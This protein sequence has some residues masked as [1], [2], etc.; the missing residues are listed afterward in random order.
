MPRWWTIAPTL[1][2][3]ASR[4]TSW[5]PCAIRAEGPGGTP[6]LAELAHPV[7]K[8]PRQRNHHIPADF[9]TIL[10]KALAEFPHERYATA[11][12]LADDLHRFLEGEPI[13]ASP[14]S[15]VKPGRQ[16]GQ[17]APG[18]GRGGGRHALRRHHRPSR[19]PGRPW[20]GWRAA[21]ERAYAELQDSR[22]AGAGQPGTVPRELPSGVHRAGSALHANRRTIGRHPR[23]RR[24]A[25]ST[26][27]RKH[28]LLP[29]AQPAV[30]RRPVA[31]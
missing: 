31:G 27:R 12:E 5:P 30:V 1:T 15:L 16:V 22:P 21:T 25:P 13:L 14:P 19:E 24:R 6:S 29:A 2:R 8:P 28:R 11:Q 9:Q 7:C 23:R 3:W 20:A 4:C 26:A 18:R 10:M 17:A